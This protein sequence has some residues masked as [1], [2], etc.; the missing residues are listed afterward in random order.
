MSLRQAIRKLEN[1][2]SEHSRE[3]F[4]IK[5][6]MSSLEAAAKRYDSESAIM[7]AD[8]PLAPEEFSVTIGKKTY[9]KHGEAGEAILSAVDAMHSAGED[10]RKVGTYGGFKLSV[11]DVSRGDERRAVLTISGKGEYQID[12]N[13]GSSG[14]GLGLRLANTVRNLKAEAERTAANAKRNRDDIPKLQAQVKPWGFEAEL[15]DAKARHN[16]VIEQLKPKKKPEEA[17]PEGEVRAS[18]DELEAI[19]TDLETDGTKRTQALAEINARQ[20]ADA[21]LY[22]ENNF[23][24]I[25]EELEDSNKVD[26]KC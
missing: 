13:P 5:D 22:V 24:A 19:F 16:A 17:K 11:E 23:W 4:R 2:Q 20:D 3:Q 15:S 25:L 18:R 21:I 9:D 1:Q 6:R 26:I 8:A 7:D 12:A 10:S 14:S